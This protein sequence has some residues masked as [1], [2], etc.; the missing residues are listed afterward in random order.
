MSSR[1]SRTIRKDTAAYASLSFFTCQRAKTRPETDKP[2]TPRRPPLGRSETPGPR[3]TTTAMA[4]VDETY[5]VDPSCRV[6]T[7]SE[8]IRNS[9]V[10][11]GKSSRQTQQ[12]VPG[13]EISSRAVPTAG[14]KPHVQYSDGSQRNPK[15]P[16]KTFASPQVHG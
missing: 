12:T 14:P 9:E 15:N 1:S 7:F 16:R 4:A 8:K 13:R 10:F 6:N 11:V 2:E 3:Q 5:L